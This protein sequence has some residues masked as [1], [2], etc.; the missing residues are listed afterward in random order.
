MQRNNYSFILLFFFSTALFGQSFNIMVANPTSIERMNETITINLADIFQSYPKLKGKTFG[1]FQ[2]QSELVSQVVDEDFNGEPD[3]LIFQSSFKPKEKKNFLL[4]VVPKAAENKS[5]V[6]GLFVNPRQDFAW[7]NDRIAFRAYGSSLA[8]DVKNGID[9][10]TKRVRYPIVDKWYK[11]EEKTPKISNHEDHGEGA[12]YFSVGKSLGCGSAGI[13]WNDKLLQ[14]GL[15]S[16]YKI[17]TNG[18]I[19]ISF[20]LYYPDWKLDSLKYLEIK[21]ITLDAGSNLNKIEERF[22]SN[23]PLDEITLAAGLVKRKGAQVK[24]H[25]EKGWMTLWG[26]TSTDP[27]A[28]YLGTAV[29]FPNSSSAN[30]AEDETNWLLTTTI[31]S[32]SAFTYYSGAGWTRSGYFAS[33]K[34]WDDYV[35]KFSLLLQQPLIVTILKSK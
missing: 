9:V 33:E 27:S 5:V 17:V 29:I 28:G 2:F 7:E 16:Y 19:R 14:A 10:W 21:R 24:Q 20:E 4:K 11:G 18:P 35:D 30:S 32:N 34:D 3:I 1:V 22:I 15:F 25:P 8:G 13:M 23:Q 12:D 6:D 31:K 26:T